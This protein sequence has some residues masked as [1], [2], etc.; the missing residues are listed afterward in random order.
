MQRSYIFPRLRLRQF[1]DVDSYR[2]DQNDLL[3]VFLRLL[4][5]CFLALLRFGC[6]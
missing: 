5:A 3:T 6:A 1:Y 2:G 4:R